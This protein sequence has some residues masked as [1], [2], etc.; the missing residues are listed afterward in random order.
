MG[1]LLAAN[2]RGDLG[3]QP[4][5]HSWR[6]LALTPTRPA[7]ECHKTSPRHSKIDSHSL[8]P[9]ALVNFRSSHV[10]VGFAPYR[11]GVRRWRTRTRSFPRPLL[12]LLANQQVELLRSFRWARWTTCC[13][14]RG[15]EA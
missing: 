9:R 1:N 12:V 11:A 4:S 8:A 6:S 2:G 15:G 7:I 10:S 5:G 3:S 14:F 13:G